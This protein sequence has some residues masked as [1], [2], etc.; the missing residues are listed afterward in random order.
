MIERYSTPDMTD[1]W[2]DESKFTKWCQ[3]EQM[4]AVAQQAPPAVVV[5]LSD[6]DRWPTPG[7]VAEAEERTNHDVV[8]FL[9]VWRSKISEETGRWL[10]HN[11][12]SSDLVDTATA[13]QVAASSDIL[14]YPLWKLVSTMADHAL[15]HRETVRV[16]RT[17]GQWAELTVWGHRVAD[18]AMG[19]ARSR[20]RL[21][22]ATRRAA[23]GKLSGPVGDHKRITPDTEEYAMA[24]LGLVPTTVST[25]VVMRDGLVDFVTACA[26]ACNVVE[27]LATEVR[28][29]QRTEVGEL[30]EG[31]K[32]GQRGSSAMPHKRNPIL[33]ERLCGIAR[34]VR[35]QIVPVMEGVALHHE[36][37]ISHSS[38]ERV[39]LPMVAQLTHYALLK[40]I[41]L[42][43]DLH[44]DVDRM[45]SN[46]LEATRV[47]QSAAIKDWL[48][49][50]GVNADTAWRL[51]HLAA[52]NP[53][54]NL[55][56]ETK[57][58]Y[59]AWFADDDRIDWKPMFELTM[60][61]LAE[62]VGDTTRWVEA[63]KN[64]H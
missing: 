56:E 1:V 33:S 59:R 55:A 3:V 50:Q 45:K 51:V 16:G 29:S 19:V 20:D 9:E 15:A 58:E 10:H 26:Q 44:V 23:V 13:L 57:R 31:F 41:E 37:D 6:P 2:S 21:D 17:H 47:T 46:A 30:A 52:R 39:A 32:P 8:A 34:L 62:Q 36:R 14:D 48:I 61:P 25:Q 11:M 63:M 54:G 12:T 42:V 22:E 43:E 4:A 40:A 18:L 60:K 35:S 53:N 28:L 24:G 7:E 5:E 27:A 64:L 38:V 49:E